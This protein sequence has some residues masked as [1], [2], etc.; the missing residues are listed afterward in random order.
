MRRLAVIMLLIAVLLGGVA[1]GH[2]RFVAAQGTSMAD[3]P[4]IG[5]WVVHRDPDISNWPNELMILSADGTAFDY[6]AYQS[7]GV[8]VWQPTGANTATV[9]F[10]VTSDGPAYIVIRASIEVAPDRHSYMGT[11]TIEAVFDPAHGGTS[12][13]IGPGKVEGTRMMAQAPGTPKA[14]LSEFFPNLGTPVATPTS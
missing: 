7:T 5:S 10:T 2:G 8:G 12:G 1:A 6:G 3:H 13:E 4:A 9:T 11:F 14:S